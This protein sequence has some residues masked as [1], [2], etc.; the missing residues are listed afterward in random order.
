MLLDL[1]LLVLAVPVLA[2]SGYLLLLTLLSGLKP[3]PPPVAPRLKFDVII[4]CLLYTS[5]AADE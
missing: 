2:A 4:P 3:A 1:L 5:D